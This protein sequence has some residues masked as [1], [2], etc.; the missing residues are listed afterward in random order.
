MN[1]YRRAAIAV[2]LFTSVTGSTVAETVTVS[3]REDAIRER[4]RFFA[5]V[6]AAVAAGDTLEVVERDGDWVQVEHRGTRGCINE[7]ALRD[8]RVLFSGL[9]SDRGGSGAS[10]DEVS[11]AG[12]GFNATVESEYQRGDVVQDY[13][14]V[15]SVERL[16]VDLSE[17]R[18]FLENGDLL[19]P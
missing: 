4:C 10:A 5:S 6:V 1:G 7:S 14:S 19:L 16:S 17:L 15:D 9:R 13:E 12:K 3:A 18:R 8:D 2:A 11:L